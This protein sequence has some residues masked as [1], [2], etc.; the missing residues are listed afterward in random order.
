MFDGEARKL[1]HETHF[2]LDEQNCY[3]M[4]KRLVAKARELNTK[5]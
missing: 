3:E 1:R 5:E 2:P 4:G